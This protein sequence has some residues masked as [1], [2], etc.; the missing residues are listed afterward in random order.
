[1][2]IFIRDSY[3]EM[4]RAA[5]KQIAK[6]IKEKPNSVIGLATGSAHTGS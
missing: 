1:M 6:Q 5:A 2:A 3:D 4:S